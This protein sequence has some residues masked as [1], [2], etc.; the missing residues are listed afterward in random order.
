MKLLLCS[1]LVL[2]TTA[3]KA[4]STGSSK[5]SNDSIYV[6][7]AKVQ[8]HDLRNYTSVFMIHQTN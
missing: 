7:D 6:A 4:Q 3:L 8:I 2:I 1:L 5:N